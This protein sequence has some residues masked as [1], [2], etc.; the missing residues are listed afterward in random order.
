MYNCNVPE[1]NSLKSE[2]EELLKLCEKSECEGLGKS[3]FEGPTEESKI[4]KWEEE[5]GVKIPESYKEWLRVS[6]K[7][8]IDGTTAT[9][10]GPDE[11]NSNYV[12]DDFVVIGE[13][14][15]DGE[16]VCFSKKT[17]EIINFFEGHITEEHE[18]FS[19][20]IKEIIELLRGEFGLSEEAKELFMKFA[21]KSLE[22]KQQK[23]GEEI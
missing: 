17:G 10:W 20:I 23:E 2:I 16:V 15:G 12:P 11:F 4:S 14:I 9:F 7:C 18:S 6:E 8:Q 3:Y 1:N 21:Q 19:K 5:N 13:M 22:K